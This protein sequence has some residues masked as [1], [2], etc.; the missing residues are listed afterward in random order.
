MQDQWLNRGRWNFK[1]QKGSSF[2][3]LQKRRRGSFLLDDFALESEKNA[4]F[5]SETSVQG[6]P[7]DSD[8]LKIRFIAHHSSDFY[9]V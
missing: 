7:F 3:G 5:A 2:R 6:V 9:A 4:F 1:K 8:D